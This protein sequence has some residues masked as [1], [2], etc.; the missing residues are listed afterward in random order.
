MNSSGIYGIPLKSAIFPTL[1]ERGQKGMHLRFFPVLV[2]LCLVVLLSGCFQGLSPLPP[3]GHGVIEGRAVLPGEQAL[4][5]SN[6][7]PLADA[8]VYVLSMVTEEVIASGRTTKEGIYRIVTPSGGPYLVKVESRSITVYAPVARIAEGERKNVGNTDFESTALAAVAFMKVQ[9]GETFTEEELNSLA[10]KEE[11]AKLV[12]EI[13]KA[14]QRGADPLKDSNVTRLAANIVT[15]PQ[16]TFTPAI[17]PQ[18]GSR[19]SFDVTTPAKVYTSARAVNLDVR[20]HNPQG[21]PLLWGK[22]FVVVLEASGPGSL[23]ERSFLPVGSFGFAFL[24][25]ENGRWIGYCGFGGGLKGI[26]VGTSFG[27]NVGLAFANSLPPGQYTLTFYLV[28]VGGIDNEGE[29]LLSF[30]GRALAK[31]VKQV[32]LTSQVGSPEIQVFVDDFGGISNQ[33]M[34]VA[35]VI[36]QV[37]GD[38]ANTSFG[39]LFAI[40][41]PRGVI[42]EGNVGIIPFFS[43]Q[44]GYFD[45]AEALDDILSTNTPSALQKYRDD[46]RYLGTDGESRWIGYYGCGEGLAGMALQGSSM[47]GFFLAFANSAPLGQYEVEVYLVKVNNLTSLD[48]LRNLPRENILAASKAYVRLAGTTG[49]PD[50]SRPYFGTTDSQA[51]FN[52]SIG[53]VFIPYTLYNPLALS[54]VYLVVHLEGENIM[55]TPGNDVMHLGF[56]NPHVGL[57]FVYPNSS[58]P[59]T[60]SDF[61]LVWRLN[62]LSIPGNSSQIILRLSTGSTPGRVQVC[63]LDKQSAPP[64]WGDWSYSGSCVGAIDV[65]VVEGTGPLP[66]PPENP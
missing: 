16:T 35:S 45:A 42:Q 43:G 28:D 24:G 44:E 12:E 54:E 20:V 38:E 61:L 57:E 37:V 51:E 3:K 17:Q 29:L 21:D 10:Q 19:F 55:F 2:V 46:I 15:I 48:S 62:I 34:V 65:A 60:G 9:K 50:V 22:S 8:S 49:I 63:L 33:D 1:A 66:P 31:V 56:D 47:H 6:F 23:G 30:R 39:L 7:V 52:P 11:F 26:T 64:S 13:R 4:K 14:Q 58:E 36:V 53:S 27:A 32:E 41:P 25:V 40:K 5:D 18:Y 59:I